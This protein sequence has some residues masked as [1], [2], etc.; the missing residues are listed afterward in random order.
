MTARN[1]LWTQGGSTSAEEDRALA[2]GLYTAQ[3][4]GILGITGADGKV[5]QN[6]T[7]N[8]SVNVA[9]FRCVVAGTENALQG[10]YQGWLDASA[11]VVIAASDP[12][13]PRIDLIVARFKDA[14]Y[15]G[16]TNSFTVE[17][18]TGTA[19][20]SPVAPAAPANSFIIAQIAVA[21]AA[22]TVVTANI[23]DKRV[24]TAP[25]SWVMPW[26]IVGVAIVTSN[27]QGTITAEVDVTGLTTSWTAVANRVYRT[28]TY[29]EAASSVGTDVIQTKICDGSSAQLQRSEL[30]LPSTT[31]GQTILCELVEIGTVAAGVA[32]RKLRILRASG[33]GVVSIVNAASNR[34]F[35]ITVEDLGPVGNP[36]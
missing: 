23:T 9:P 22:T 31:F 35:I 15:S 8:M 1:A 5:T 11:N 26:G 33:T 36:A 29:I 32:T 20:G 7:P 6:G 34:P 10:I 30:T 24:W 16:A 19:A 18:V 3:G 12:S 25:R 14:Q 2:T 17:A 21:A 28:K 4:S 13:N 27:S